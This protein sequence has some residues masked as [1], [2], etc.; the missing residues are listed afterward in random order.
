M[1]RKKIEI[2]P[3]TVCIISPPLTS[4]MSCPIPTSSLRRA[5]FASVVLTFASASTSPPILSPSI[6]SSPIECRGFAE[7][8]QPLRHFPKGSLPRLSS[9]KNSI[10]D[11]PRAFIASSHYTLAFMT[12]SAGPVYSRKRTSSAS[13]ARSTSQ[14]SFLV[15]PRL[16]CCLFYFW[17]TFTSLS[18]T[19]IL[20]VSLF[21]TRRML[22]REATRACRKALSVL[23]VGHSR[24]RRPSTAGT[25][26]LP[27]LTL[28]FVPSHIS[29]GLL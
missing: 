24:H 9:C 16:A 23:L 3:I 20:T 26:A 22:S 18:S 4:Y 14:S 8:A 1:G 28:T 29:V 21:N 19:T 25:S 2:Q 11:P 17:L 10:A 12:S 7:R 5:I 15:R 27:Y 6:F 13:F